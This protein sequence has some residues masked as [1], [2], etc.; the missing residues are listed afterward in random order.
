MKTKARDPLLA[1]ITE[2]EEVFRSVM[3]RQTL[4]LARRRR[5]LRLARRALATMGAVALATVLLHQPTKV[6]PLSAPRVTA[7]PS[8]RIVHSIPLAR[9]ECVRTRD[10]LF[11]PVERM[12]GGLS[13]VTS[14]NDAVALIDT[15][16]VAPAIELLDDRRLLGTLSHEHAAIIAA[17]TEEAQLIFF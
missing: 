9:N 2:D 5:R 6:A 4:A 7:V 12:S 15:K 17:G 1:V 10:D 3:L 11:T 8:V 16:T 14:R 13:A